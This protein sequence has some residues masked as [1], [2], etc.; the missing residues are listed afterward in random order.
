[1]HPVKTLDRPNPHCHQITTGHRPRLV[2]AADHAGP[3][4]IAALR[5]EPAALH[6]TTNDEISV[7]AEKARAAAM[8]GGRASR[9][10]RIKCDTLI[11]RRTEKELVDAGKHTRA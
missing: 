8:R 6:R 2:P 5:G 1:M 11:V 4:G 7:R 10:L 9:Q 3:G